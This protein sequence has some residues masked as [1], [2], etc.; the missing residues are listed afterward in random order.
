MNGNI[1]SEL[2]KLFGITYQI[3]F[4]GYMN[5][6]C[7]SCNYYGLFNRGALGVSKMRKLVYCYN[8]NRN[9]KF[10]PKWKP[11]AKNKKSIVQ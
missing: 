6:Y 11:V 9:L 5:T 3:I 10:N 8:Q 4:K 7:G 1:S 2:L